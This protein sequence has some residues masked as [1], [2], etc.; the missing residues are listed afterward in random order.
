[1]L[2]QALNV[3]GRDKERFLPSD[4]FLDAIGQGFPVFLGQL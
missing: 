4:D 2:S 3:R 1:M